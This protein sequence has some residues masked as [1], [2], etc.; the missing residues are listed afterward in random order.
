MVNCTKVLENSFNLYWNQIVSLI[1]RSANIGCMHYSKW[2]IITLSLENMSFFGSGISGS[3][4]EE[5]LLDESFLLV[6][7]ALL[8]S[9]CLG[10]SVI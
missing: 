9:E 10:T 8:S 3:L 1:A 6:F 7:K 2:K 5:M 4:T